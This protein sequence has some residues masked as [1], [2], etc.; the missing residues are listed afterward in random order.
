M[1]RIGIINNKTNYFFESINI[2][3]LQCIKVYN[4]LRQDFPHDRVLMRI[5][6]YKLQQN[7]FKNVTNITISSPEN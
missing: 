1:L 2:L 6:K 7:F 5:I 3:M 4:T